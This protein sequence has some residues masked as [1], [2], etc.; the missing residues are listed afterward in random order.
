MA[1]NRN[2]KGDASPFDQATIDAVWRKAQELSGYDP[3]DYRKDSC[4]ALIR[5]ASYGTT[6]DYGW[7]IDHDK[8]VA[9]GGT[10]DL[11]NL[12]PL[13]WEN[14]RGKGD[15]WPTWTCTISDKK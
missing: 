1:R 13:H 11:S 15:N 2:T 3:N 7:E 4:G 10:D 6:G 5:K 14:N 9:K 8:P 12:K